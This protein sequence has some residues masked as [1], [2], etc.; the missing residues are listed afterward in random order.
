MRAPLGAKYD[1]FGFIAEKL[2]TPI[3]C[4]TLKHGNC[5][6]VTYYFDFGC[7]RKTDPTLDKF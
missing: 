1:T 7:T 4:T 2:F 6:H 5:A 3:V